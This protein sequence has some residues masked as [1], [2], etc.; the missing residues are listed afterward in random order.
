MELRFAA[1]L[2]CIDGRVQL[3]VINWIKDNYDVD[4]VDMIT[5]AGM[6]GAL[7]DVNFDIKDILRKIG[8]SIG[9]HGSEHIF[10]VGHYDCAGN[11]VDNKT[12]KKQIKTASKRIKGFTN[13]CKIIGLWVSEELSVE[14][15]SE[16]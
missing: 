8:I 11:P 3:P 13:S 2:N 7:A 14:K 12:H 1:C 4:Y 5:E 16:I 15:I 6:N 9:I 10:I